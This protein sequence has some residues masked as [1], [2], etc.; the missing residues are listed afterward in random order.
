MEDILNKASLPAPTDLRPGAKRA[1][2]LP[3][4]LDGL[5]VLLQPP[6]HLLLQPAVVLLVLRHGRLHPA[7]LVQ[8]LEGDRTSS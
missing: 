3:L 6:A 4:S 2:L 8:Q 5:L 1:D 7:Q